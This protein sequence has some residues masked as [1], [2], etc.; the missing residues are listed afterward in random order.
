MRSWLRVALV[1]ALVVVVVGWVV[2]LAIRRPLAGYMARY[3]SD[4][5]AG[6]RVDIGAVDVR[7]FTVGARL[8]DVSVQD[9]E[10]RQPP[11]LVAPTV[12]AGLG[13]HGRHPSLHA[14]VYDARVEIDQARIETA[15]RHDLAGQLQRSGH[16]GVQYAWDRFGAVFEE[17]RLEG[18]Q[19]A[20]RSGEQVVALQPLEVRLRNASGKGAGGNDDVFDVRATVGVPEGG[21]VRVA[22]RAEL[23]ALPR[24]AMAMRVRAR[25]VAL[26]A[27]ASA[28]RERRLA[29]RGGR[30]SAAVDLDVSPSRVAVRLADVRLRGADLEYLHPEVRWAAEM[31]KATA[32]AAEARALAARYGVEARVDRMVI[33]D[34][35]VGLRAPGASPPYRVFLTIDRAEAEHVTT[36]P[37]GPPGRIALDAR[38]MGRGALDTEAQFRRVARGGA[39]V[40]MRVAMRDVPLRALND[41]LQAHGAPPLESGRLDLA[42]DASVRG[43]RIDGWVEPVIEEVDL[44]TARD[45]GLGE[46]IV[47]GAVD[48]VTG[49]LEDD[50]D[51][52]ATRTTLSGTLQDPSVGVWQAIVG[53]LR[54]AY[55]EA[56]VPR[57]E[58]AM[59]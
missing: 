54:N 52:I 10:R 45:P 20:W 21:K 56:V 59:R 9:E 13:F 26:D 7:P 57:W 3:A 50:Q 55:V 18:A 46:R 36:A 27:F 19:A 23:F 1:V 5:V 44:G 16:E 41:A 42:L 17:V 14:T 38:P 58:Q 49:L 31:D 6:Y 30:A 2:P 48:A 53:V 34:T 37:G 12:E 33:E 25:E 24:P 4:S 51:R 47:E 43:G 22:G 40:E 8:R 35:T 29:V 15:K 11:L 39:D 32:A 28:A